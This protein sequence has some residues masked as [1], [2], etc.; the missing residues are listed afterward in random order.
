MKGFKQATIHPI[1]LAI[2]NVHRLY[3]MSTQSQMLMSPFQFRIKLAN[4]YLQLRADVNV[5]SSTSSPHLPSDTHLYK[6]HFLG[7]IPPCLSRKPS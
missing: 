7:K 6:C 3:Q 5:S 1:D 4:K 2:V